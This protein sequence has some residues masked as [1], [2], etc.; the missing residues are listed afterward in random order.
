MVQ[1][2][3]RFSLNFDDQ[4]PPNL[5]MHRSHT[6]PGGQCRGIAFRGASCDCQ[7]NIRTNV[8]NVLGIG[9]IQGMCSQTDFGIMNRE[10][11]LFANGG[12]DAVYPQ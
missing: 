6:C 8:M 9:D 12:F 11:F 7:G 4:N 10:I 5:M 2:K 3:I 1:E